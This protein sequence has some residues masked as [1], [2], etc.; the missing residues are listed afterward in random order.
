M[1]E[2]NRDFCDDVRREEFNI[3][4]FETSFKKKKWCPKHVVSFLAF[5]HGVKDRE[6]V[7]SF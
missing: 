7:L 3:Q 6:I 4:L 2:N 1:F 5:G